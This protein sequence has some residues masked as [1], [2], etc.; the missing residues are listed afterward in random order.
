MNNLSKMVSQDPQRLLRDRDFAA[1]K[2]SRGNTSHVATKHIQAPQKF[3]IL[4]QYDIA[5]KSIT[6][7]RTSPFPCRASAAP[8]HPQ[9]ILHARRALQPMFSSATIVK[10]FLRMQDLPL[11]PKTIKP[12]M[13]REEDWIWT[14]DLSVTVRSAAITMKSIRC[15]LNLGHCFV[16]VGGRGSLLSSPARRVYADL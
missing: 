13:V 12:R 15:C 16:A 8:A 2:S 10:F 1:S 11:P 6:M 14:N 9:Q 4:G 7:T 3:D 5:F